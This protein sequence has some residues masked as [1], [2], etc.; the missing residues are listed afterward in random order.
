LAENQRE[1]L[2]PVKFSDKL[3]TFIHWDRLHFGKDID[4]TQ[5]K[6]LPII[7]DKIAGSITH[8]STSEELWDSDREIDRFSRMFLESRDSHSTHKRTCWDLHTRKRDMGG[9]EN[10]KMKEHRTLRVL[11]VETSLRDITVLKKALQKFPCLEELS[12]RSHW[13][14]NNRTVHSINIETILDVFQEFGMN[15]KTLQWDSDGCHSLFG[16]YMHLLQVK[17]LF[18]STNFLQ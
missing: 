15:I 12:I 14:A 8:F 5:A 3:K 2:R 11:K 6:I 4:S 16:I 18:Y 17:K 7:L 10:L 1:H 13:D 9:V